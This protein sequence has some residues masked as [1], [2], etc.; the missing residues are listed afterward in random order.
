MRNVVLM[1]L[2]LL[3]IGA[4]V[5]WQNRNLIHS[6]FT[7]GYILL[8]SLFLLTAFGMRKRI[9]SIAQLGSAAFWMQ[10]H[11]Y[12]G[13]A[14]FVMFGFHV[15]WRIPSGGFEILLTTLYLIVAISGVYGLYATRTIPRKLTAIHDEVIYERIPSFRAKLAAE[16]RAALPS[17]ADIAD[18]TTVRGIQVHVS[19]ASNVEGMLAAAAA[20]GI[21]LGGWG[22]RDSIR[23]IELRQAHCGTSEY[24]IWEKPAFSCNPPTARP[25]Q[26]L[27]E[28]GLAI[29]FT[30]NGGSMTSRSNPG[31]QWLA[32][33]AG[34]W[35]FVN[36]P[37]EPW[38]WSTT[39]Q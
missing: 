36:L 7:T 4:L 12:V 27:H 1:I 6:T 8:G 19:I 14:T 35:G 3:A 13:L 34:Q 5:L 16:A 25:G 31:F 9:P 24:D 33:N 32:S 20:D 29:D 21:D 37:S 38:H 11:I 15:G 23:Q 2:A 18:I 10:M 26:S 30:Y 22:Y 39:G 17:V 28:R